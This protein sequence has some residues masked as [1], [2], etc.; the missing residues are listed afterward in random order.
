MSKLELTMNVKPSKYLQASH[1]R[2]Q[3][4]NILDGIPG[5]SHCIRVP[6]D[7]SRS[8]LQQLVGGTRQTIWNNVSAQ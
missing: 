2:N 8:L 1:W 6:L 4:K 3:I 5:A 7:F